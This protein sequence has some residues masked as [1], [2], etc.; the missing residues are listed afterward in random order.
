MWG[1]IETVHLFRL[2]SETWTEVSLCYLSEMRRSLDLRY[3]SSRTGHPAAHRSTWRETEFRLE[4]PLL[5]VSSCVLITIISTLTQLPYCFRNKMSYGHFI[6]DSNSGQEHW[7]AG[8]K[9]FRWHGSV[10][11]RRSG[12][13]ECILQGGLELYEDCKVDVQTCAAHTFSTWHSLLQRRKE[14]DVKH[15]CSVP[16][17]DPGMQRIHSSGGVSQTISAFSHL[18]CTWISMCPR[19]FSG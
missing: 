9:V 17:A 1:I 2:H 13:C 19:L 14:L 7:W 15:H 10:Y 11:S 4:Q 16:N 3:S 5:H 6:T 18:N 12:S 8:D